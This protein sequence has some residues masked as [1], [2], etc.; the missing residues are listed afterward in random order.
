MQSYHK[1]LIETQHIDSQ[2]I[3]F[4]KKHMLDINNEIRLIS[5]MMFTLSPQDSDNEYSEWK[6]VI[7][8]SL[9]NKFLYL[10]NRQEILFVL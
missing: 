5:E 7:F 10:L 1:L 6:E 4:L 9:I 8:D 3:S 2:K